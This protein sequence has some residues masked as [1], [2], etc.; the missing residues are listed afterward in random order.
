MASVTGSKK[1]KHG[2]DNGGERA[3]TIYT[4]IETCKINDLDPRARL[5]DVLAYLPDY[6]AKRIDEVLP[7]N[8]RADRQQ[9]KVA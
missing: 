7:W 3:S 5:T 1:T 8:W 2:E 9:N 6:S 4:L